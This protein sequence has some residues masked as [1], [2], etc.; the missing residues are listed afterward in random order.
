MK[1]YELGY[2]DGYKTGVENGILK[3][4]RLSVFDKGSN[5][6]E[7]VKEFHKLF[8]HPVLKQP[9]II[10]QE[11]GAMRIRLLQEELKELIEGFHN[12]D[13]VEVADA[14]A[15]LQYVL[16]GA[17]LEFGL[18]D[19]FDSLFNEVHR[20]NMSKVA[21]SE[22]EARASVLHYASIQGKDKCE[23][24]YKTDGNGNYFIIR[25]HDSK[26]LK[27]VGYSKADLR[28]I[29]NDDNNHQPEY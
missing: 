20:S 10:D 17:V 5:Y 28:S 3:Q 18:N 2:K 6:L 4:K 1:D 11:R 23:A 9:T 22:D 8:K 16:S 19:L 7:Q 15:D 26:T 14:L 25:L 21:H 12:K 24:D 29:L 13:I 27:P